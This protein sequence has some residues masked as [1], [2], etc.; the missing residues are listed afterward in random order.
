VALAQHEHMV[1]ALALLGGAA[2]WPIAV[3]A[4]QAAMP[5]IGFLREMP[6]KSGFFPALKP[7]GKK[8]RGFLA[9]GALARFGRVLPLGTLGTRVV[10][11]I[12]HLPGCCRDACSRIWNH[13]VIGRRGKRVRLVGNEASAT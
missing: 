1:H 3:Q 8:K 11:R 9:S 12:K 6:I 2:A 13:E 5:V 7:V 10:P 4:Q